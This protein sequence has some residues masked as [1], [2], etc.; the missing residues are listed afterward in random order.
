M[1]YFCTPN[2]IIH[3]LLPQGMSSELTRTL[4]PENITPLGMTFCFGQV[5]YYGFCFLQIIK[6]EKSKFCVGVEE[7]SSQ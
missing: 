1:L 4:I 3:Y 6:E 2:N 5:M 7:N